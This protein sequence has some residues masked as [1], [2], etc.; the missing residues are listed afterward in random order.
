M[1]WLSATWTRSIIT[2]VVM[3]AMIAVIKIGRE[4]GWY[5]NDLSWGSCAGDLS[6]FEPCVTQD[7]SLM[8]THDGRQIVYP[9]KEE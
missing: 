8:V 3:L 7:G 5:P 6:T 2:T 9:M 4:Q 1:Q